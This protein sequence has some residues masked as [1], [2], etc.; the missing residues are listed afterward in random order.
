MPSIQTPVRTEN[1]VLLQWQPVRTLREYRA[2]GGLRALENVR[3]NSPEQIIAT[4][5]RAGLR[6]R[7]GAGFPTATKW[8]GVRTSGASQKFVCC[9]GAEGEP[10]T[11]KDRYL[12][13]NNPYQT[14]EGLAI[15]LDVVGGTRAYI[16]LKAGFAPE[17]EAVERSLGEMSTA[18]VPEADRIELV[19]GPDEYLF[20]EEKAM[21]EVI[22]G[23]LPLPRVFPPYIHG[24]FGAV[25]GGPSP[26]ESN[27][28]VVNNVETLAHVPHIINHGVR[29][30]RSLGSRESP[31]TMVFSVSGDVRHEIVRELPLGTTLRELIFGVAG[32]PKADRRV[33]AVFP[34]LANAVITEDA[35]DTALGFDSMKEA[36]S[37]LGSGGFIV[38][39]DTACMVAVAYI[40]ANFLYV[41]SCNQCLPCKI[42]GREIT[43]RLERLLGGTG[44]GADIDGI[45]TATATVEE[46][47]R[48]FLPSS[49]SLVVSS[50]VRNFGDDFGGHTG[51]VTC[52]LRHDLVL[53]KFLDYVEGEGFSYDLNYVRKQPDWT[54]AEA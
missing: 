41:E 10:G 8:D 33:K 17:R 38:Y 29:S 52:Q 2:H 4:L 3:R 25:Y 51:G 7:G 12:L 48:C 23:G 43:E 11:F 53:P 24:L 47:Q 31:G 9:N 5:R 34:G 28:T 15:A 27:P 13:R 46:G 19:L 16:C 37:A 40:L 30:F 1:P 6:G 14:L 42:G 20:G 44:E 54:Y 50:I 18:G 49:T 22:E 26:K 45:M 21:L 32:G 35:F 36:G 39:D